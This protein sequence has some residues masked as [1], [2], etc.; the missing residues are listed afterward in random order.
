VDALWETVR[1]GGDADTNAAIVGGIVGSA[2]GY[3]GI[4]PEWLTAREDLEYRTF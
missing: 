2:C 3:E 4:P 1:A